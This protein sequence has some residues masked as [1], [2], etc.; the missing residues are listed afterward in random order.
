MIGRDSKLLVT[1]VLVLVWKTMGEQL[2]E[3]GVLV[4]TDDNFDQAVKEHE[5]LLVEFYAPWCGH[6]IALEPEYKKAA[7]M[8]SEADSPVSLAKVDATK[9]KK[10]AEKFKIEGFPTLK[11]FNQG[12]PSEYSGP[13]E[14]E[15]IVDWLTKKSGPQWT[16]VDSKV[17]LEKLVKEKEA[18]AV[19]FFSDLESSWAATK[20]F[21]EVA[22]MVDD[23]DFYI[24]SKP[25]TMKEI[26][27]TE[28]SI[29]VMK[30]F[31]EPVVEFKESLTKEN[32]KRFIE[33][34]ARPLITEFK[35]EHAHKIFEMEITH[36]FLL[37]VD[38]AEK[39]FDAMLKTL[40]TVAKE[41]RQKMT[42]VHLD[43]G[44]EENE[45][46]AEFFGVTKDTSPT[47]AIFEMEG[48]SK[49]LPA[50]EKAKEI[51][52]EN[53]KAFVV[54]YF[55]GNLQKFL[56]SEPLPEDWDATAVKTLVSSNFEQV[57]KDKSKDV[58]VKFYAPWC[59]H[60][61]AIAPIWDQIGEKYSDKG[62]LVIAKVD[63]TKNEIDGVDIEGF[64]TIKM[65]KKESNEE[66]EYIGKKDLESMVKFIETGEQEEAD[67]EEDYDEDYDDDFDDDE[68][69]EDED[70][71]DDEVEEESTDAHDEL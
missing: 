17:E 18:I 16:E 48:S 49:Y 31:D 15:G 60:C 4:L 57:A 46:I 50:P 52:A 20:L 19:G 8:L 13:R 33:D 6:C 68:D 61:K 24:V 35:Q 62:D 51:T 64:P 9:E 58:F 26:G 10:V 65:F 34:A 25:A 2:K 59:G 38:K 47:F 22:S 32:L 70:A 66:I 21:R 53:L 42:F 44:N 27:A 56:K 14:A 54:E 43:I 67:E 69:G 63:S 7:K 3:G 45:G 39:D 30:S 29:R 55:A 36:H 28:A 5:M 40:R 23:V 37:F 71:E 11:F 1:L 41:H 12:Q